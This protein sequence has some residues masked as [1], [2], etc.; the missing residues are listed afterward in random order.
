M[1]DTDG[2][3][4]QNLQKTYSNGVHALSGVSLN[5]PPGALW[6][7]GPQRRRQEYLDAYP[8]YAAGA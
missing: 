8:S 2:L 5:V 1:P 4:I 3:M 6:P 7:A